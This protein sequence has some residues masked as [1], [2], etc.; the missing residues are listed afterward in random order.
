MDLCIFACWGLTPFGKPLL[1]RITSSN[2]QSY[3]LNSS[4]HFPRFANFL[5]AGLIRDLTNIGWWLFSLCRK[6]LRCS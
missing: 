5:L 4:V 3:S 2:N 1:W 6:W